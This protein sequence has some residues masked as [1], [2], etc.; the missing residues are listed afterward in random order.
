MSLLMNQMFEF[1]KNISS[2]N[3][4][5]YDFIDPRIVS[6]KLNISQA[7]SAFL[8]NF[9]LYSHKCKVC[10][11][12]QHPRDENKKFGPY[13]TKF[14]IPKTID[15]NSYDEDDFEVTKNLIKKVYKLL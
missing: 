15:P 3:F 12:V 8:L 11:Y 13:K 7:K 9:L 2:V 1:L 10:Y 5:E 6:S 14:D 4:G